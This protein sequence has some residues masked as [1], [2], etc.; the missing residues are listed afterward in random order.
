[1]VDE[2]KK[3]TTLAEELERRADDVLYTERV[4]DWGKAGET[5][6]G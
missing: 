5:E 3:E 4:R 6:M 1:M 2:H